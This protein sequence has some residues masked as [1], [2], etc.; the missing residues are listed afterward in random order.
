[1][2]RCHEKLK[3]FSALANQR[4][5]IS[6]KRGRRGV[7]CVVNERQITNSDGPVV[8]SQPERKPIQAIAAKRTGCE[9][10][11]FFQQRSR[12][13]KMKGGD[14]AAVAG[15][16]ADRRGIRDRVDGGDKEQQANQPDGILDLQ[17]VPKSGAA[18][19]RTA[20]P[21]RDSNIVHSMQE[22]REFSHDRIGSGFRPMIAL[23]CTD[24]DWKRES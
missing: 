6:R 17:R 20:L 11:F 22:F 16:R 4:G 24:H 2:R 23:P 15:R 10:P 18:T 12:P 21:T 19:Y 13:A 8:E 3:C 5:A 1:M 9:E 7:C 14:P